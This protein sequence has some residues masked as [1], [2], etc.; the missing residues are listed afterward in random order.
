MLSLGDC[1]ELTETRSRKI[2]DAARKIHGNSLESG[3]IPVRLDCCLILEDT[4]NSSTDTGLQKGT[5]QLTGDF[6]S[7]PVTNKFIPDRDSASTFPQPMHKGLPPPLQASVFLQ[8]L[9]SFLAA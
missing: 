4:V 9:L 5:G 7:G 1:S 3:C 6:L 8:L 2:A